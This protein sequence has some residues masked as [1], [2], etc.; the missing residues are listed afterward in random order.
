MPEQMSDEQLLAELEKQQEIQK[1]NPPDS[2]RW[3]AASR[4]IHHLATENRR[5]HAVKPQRRAG[6]PL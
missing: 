1:R 6:G 3:I 4:I 5:R 2:E